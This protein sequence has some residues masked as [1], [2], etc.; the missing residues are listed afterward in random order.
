MRTG[1]WRCST[2]HLTLLNLMNFTRHVHG[3]SSGSGKVFPL[4]QVFTA[5]RRKELLCYEIFFISVSTSVATTLIL[6]VKHHS[7]RWSNQANVETLEQVLEELKPRGTGLA[8]TTKLF[9]L[10]QKLQATLP[11]AI[12]GD[13]WF[14]GCS[15][16]DEEKCLVPAV[17]WQVAEDNGRGTFP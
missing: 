10:T 13:P 11:E 5:Q 6:Q 8:W 1:I 3:C 12:E 14:S 16:D 2:W 9:K 7:P 15:R 4:L 17:E